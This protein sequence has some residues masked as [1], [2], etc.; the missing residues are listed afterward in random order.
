VNGLSIP[1]GD[2]AALEEAAGSLSRFASQI[3]TLS[4]ATRSAT[5]RIA[6]DADWTGTSADAYTA[7][8]ASFATGIG[9]ME[10]PLRGVP[11]AVA[12]YAA[13]LREAQ[14]RVREYESYAQQVNAITGPVSPQEQ[15]QIAGATQQLQHTAQ[16]ALSN[17]ETEARAAQNMLSRIVGELAQVFG[18][19]GPFHRWLETITRPWD[20]LGADAALEGILTHGET[21]EKEFQKGTK[22]AKTAQAALETALDSDFKDIV[23]RTMQDML[24]GTAGLADLQ[25]AVDNWKVVAQ[26]ETQAASKGGALSLPEETKL[27][28]M[29]PVLKNLGRAADVLGVIGG[30]YTAIAPPE[31]DHGGMRVAARS[32]GG[33]MALGSAAG[34][35]G[36]YAAA[37]SVVNAAILGSL[38]I[39]G[40]GEGVA[41]AAGLYLVGDWAYHNQHLIAHT[42][43]SARHAAAHYADDLVSWI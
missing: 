31:Y 30:T 21:L 6:A 9:G 2:P 40:I 15:A 17:L 12:G 28:K 32:A 19:D 4:D 20:S 39:P 33:A 41:A 16:T 5:G 23:G 14:S 18:A 7:F 27:L 22:A 42:F 24:K 1:P 35:I 36:S 8:T 43:D 29:L 13:A 38:T 11:G 3:T 37:D 25:N 34:L 10:S 26:W